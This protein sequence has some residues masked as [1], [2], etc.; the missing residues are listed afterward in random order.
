MAKLKVTED[1]LTAALAGY[2]TELDLIEVKMSEIRRMLGDGARSTATSSATKT[3]KR[4]FSFA[5]RRK[6]RIA[7]K[8][9]WKKIKQAVEPSQAATAKPKKRRMSAAGKAAIVAALKKR[10]AAVRA[11]KEG[12]PTVAKRAGRK[13]A[14]A[15]E[16]A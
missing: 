15:K 9:R 3:P 12:K 11:A 7:Q 8:L 6:M 16:A 1:L 5:S 2:Q 14:A 13:K 10:W 4:K